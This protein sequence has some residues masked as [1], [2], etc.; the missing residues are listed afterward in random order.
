[1]ARI[2]RTQQSAIN[3]IPKNTVTIRANQKSRTIP[4]KFWTQPLADVYL[5]VFPPA[6][7][8]RQKFLSGAISASCILKI[9]YAYIMMM[10]N[11][12]A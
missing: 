8:Q 2:K 11:G 7:S 4:I 10:K 12:P 9:L 1:M 6:P 5:S 3:I